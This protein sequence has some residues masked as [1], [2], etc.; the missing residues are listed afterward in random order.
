[1][2]RWRLAVN[3]IMEDSDTHH[4]QSGVHVR[5]GARAATSGHCFELPK[6]IGSSFLAR[7]FYARG[8]FEKSEAEI[9][10]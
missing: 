9:L 7:R 3:A 5:L 4:G 10:K 8:N 2:R 6:E 1:M